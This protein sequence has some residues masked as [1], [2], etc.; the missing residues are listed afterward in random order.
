MRARQQ[1]LRT[2]VLGGV[3]LESRALSTRSADKRM[4]K[5][6]ESAQESFGYCKEVLRHKK[7]KK[8]KKLCK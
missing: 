2:P 7:D 8:D 4:L 6:W 1:A 5:Q 3:G